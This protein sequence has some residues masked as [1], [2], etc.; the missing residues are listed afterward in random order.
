MEFINSIIA[1]FN[2][3][4][5]DYPIIAGGITLWGLGTLSW[6]CRGL[7]QF[8]LES[9]KRLFT[10]TVTLTSS[11][12]SFYSLLRWFQEKG[13][14]KKARYLKITNGKWGEDNSVLKSVGYGTHIL[15]VDKCP[16]YLRMEQKDSP[17]SNKE[18]DEITLTTLGRSHKT[19]DNLFKEIVK[20]D[21]DK[22]ISITKR[23][24][25][26]YWE[27]SSEQRAREFNTVYLGEKVKETLIE[28]LDDF[29]AKEDWYLEKGVP[30]Q[31]GIL[32][33]GPPGTGK[34]SIIKAIASHLGYQL[35]I[36]NSSML[37][38]IGK[39]IFSLPEK[40]L[41]VIEDI[42]GCEATKSRSSETKKGRLQPAKKCN[43]IESGTEEA[44]NPF[45]I[46][47]NLTTANISDILNAIDGI[48]QV[49]GRILIATTNY[50]ERLDDALLREGRFDLRI[51]IGYADN[52]IVSEIFKSFY[53]EF[54]VPDSFLIRK[55]VSTAYIQGLILRNL[56]SP[57]VV[58]NDLQYKGDKCASS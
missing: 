57:D 7:P 14:D 46:D 22:E 32:L 1:S 48:H 28:Y 9:F 18:R 40:S 29:E 11:N 51:E 47:I 56:D 54:I 26:D 37:S 35:H 41:I 10:T 45:S 24:D 50:A 43:T 49:H 17:G 3:Y 16:I 58:L 23:F 21:P 34:T 6:A 12:D 4:A 8:F 5:K 33:Y 19:I 52:F 20:I 38:G 31:T 30:Y 36:L 39:A 44:D 13:Y 42:D 27:K 2:V 53:P 15:W 25:G 55:E